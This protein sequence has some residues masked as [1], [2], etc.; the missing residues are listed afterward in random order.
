MTRPSAPAASGVEEAGLAAM[1][2]AS[3]ASPAT[4]RTDGPEPSP[5]ARDPYAPYRRTLLEAGRLRELSR[6]SPARAVRDAALCWASIGAAWTAVALWP[7][8]WVALAAL[9]AIGSRYYAL[10]IIGHDGLHRRLFERQ[11][12]NDLFNDLAILGPVG[13]ITR[14]NNRSHLDHHRYLTSELDPDRHKHGCFNKAE[15][16]A[17]AGYLAGLTS[18]LRSARHV[19]LPESLPAAHPPAASPEAARASYRA[20]DLAILAGWQLALLAGL[21]AAIGWWAYPVLWVLPVYLFT[22]LGDNLRAF[23]EHSH[24]EAD[25]AADRHRL[26]TFRSNPLERLF[27][28]PM[29]MNFHAVHHLWPSIPY[30]NLPRADREIRGREEARGLIWRGSYLA[31]LWRYARALPL[32]ECR[33][34]GGAK[35][36]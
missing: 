30:Y 34:G 27:L 14:V 7:R 2:P 3:A 26:I 12:A 25:A 23:V 6:L 33:S 21:T 35:L 10:Y 13:A 20:R 17:L 8:W 28:A 19:F 32:P 4:R 15:P 36:R 5:A 18:A 9:P 24:P 22:F 29:N 16:L 1:S 31:Y 11:A